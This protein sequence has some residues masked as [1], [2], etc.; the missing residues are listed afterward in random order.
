MTTETVLAAAEAQDIA[1]GRK[2]LFGLALFATIGLLVA[3]V[4]LG[5]PLAFWTWH[6]HQAGVQMEEAV[7]WPEPRYSDAL[8]SLQDPTLLN[9]VRRYLDEARR[10]RPNHFHAYRM[11]AVTYMAEGNWL[12][13]E[14]AIEAAVAGAERNPLVQ[15]DQVMIHEQ[16][17]DHLAAHPGQGVWQAVQDQQGTLLWP[18]VDRVCAY[19]D[20]STDCDVVNQTVPLPVHG[21]DPILIREGRLL[22]VL[23][24][25]PIEI[26]VPVLPAAPWLVFLAGVHP[27]SSPPPPAGVKLTIAVQGENHSPVTSGRGALRSGRGLGRPFVPKCGQHRLCHAHA[28]A[29]LAAVPAGWRFP[30][31]RLAGPGPGGGEPGPGGPVGRLAAPGRCGGRSRTAP[32]IAIGP[33]AASRVVVNVFHGTQCAD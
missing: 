12:A 29:A 22:A 19:L 23:S 33:A 14:R 5:V 7:S 9:S 21:I 8:P 1:P 27:E 17:M 13:A 2:W 15:F 30:Q 20:R 32:G 31:Q 28:R 4:V 18:A 16:M 25:E 3:G 26:E 10:W 11:E 6:I 24:A